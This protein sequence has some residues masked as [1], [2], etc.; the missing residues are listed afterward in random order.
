M[1]FSKRKTSASSQ[2]GSLGCESNGSYYYYYSF[3][4]KGAG[5][6]EHKAKNGD[7]FCYGWLLPM[8]FWRCYEAF[9]W[10]EL[11]IDHNLVYE[12]ENDIPRSIV[13][14]C[15][16]HTMH[17]Y[18][19]WNW[20]CFWWEFN[21]FSNFNFVECNLIVSAV[22][23]FIPFILS[24]SS[25]LELMHLDVS[26]EQYDETKRTKNYSN[27]SR[28]LHNERQI[29]SDLFHLWRASVCVRLCARRNNWIEYQVHYSSQLSHSFS[30]SFLLRHPIPVACILLLFLFISFATVSIHTIIDTFAHIKRRA[31]A[32]VCYAVYASPF[33]SSPCASRTA[34]HIFIY[35][36]RVTTR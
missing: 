10:L 34:V 36:S 9:V 14:L 19:S 33:N 3:S 25:S 6:G 4:W 2:I 15:T 21:L 7:S 27:H 24:S 26:L 29:N 12:I 31:G 20:I 18:Q 22:V 32:S 8:P 35:I 28:S 16:G 5:N 13:P 17:R 1:N 30:F 23:S 11:S